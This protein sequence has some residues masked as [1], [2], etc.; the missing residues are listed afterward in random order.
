MLSVRDAQAMVRACNQAAEMQKE[1][2]VIG[3]SSSHACG[4]PEETGS[5]NKFGFYTKVALANISCLIPGSQISFKSNHERNMFR[6]MRVPKSGSKAIGMDDTPQFWC[7]EMHHTPLVPFQDEKDGREF[8]KAMKDVQEP[9]IY[10]MPRESASDTHKKCYHVFSKNNDYCVVIYGS[11]FSY[12]QNIIP[13]L[14]LKETEG[15]NTFRKSKD[16]ISEYEKVYYHYCAL[17][18]NENYDPNDKRT[19]GLKEATWKAM[20]TKD[21][22]DAAKDSSCGSYVKRALSVAKTDT[23]KKAMINKWG[24]TFFISKLMGDKVEKILKCLESL[25]VA[26]VMMDNSPVES[27]TPKD[28]KNYNLP[29]LDHDQVVRSVT[30][31][32]TERVIQVLRNNGATVT[33]PYNERSDLMKV[34]KKTWNDL[35]G[36]KKVQ[37]HVKGILEKATDKKTAA[38]I[39]LI[40]KAQNG[41]TIS[42]Y[43]KTLLFSGPPGTGKTLSALIMADQA[44][45]PMV[46]IT[47]SNLINKYVGESERKVKDIFSLMRRLGEVRGR[48]HTGP[49]AILFMDEV[50]SLVSSKQ[51]SSHTS[52]VLTTFLEEIEGFGGGS[53]FMF[54]CCTNNK[55]ALDPAF[56][57]RM[58]QVVPFNAFNSKEIQNIFQKHA[59][60]LSEEELYR[61]AHHED[62]AGLT[63]R[64]IVSISDMAV[65]ERL[66][67]IRKEAPNVPVSKLSTMFK[68]KLAPNVDTYL[69]CLRKRV[70]ANYEDHEGGTR[71]MSYAQNKNHKGPW[72]RPQLKK[73]KKPK[74]PIIVNDDEEETL[75]EISK[76]DLDEEISKNG[77]NGEESDHDNPVND[78]NRLK[79]EV[80]DDE[81]SE[82]SGE[83]SEESGDTPELA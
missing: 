54:V 33:L 82:E 62:A 57:N 74:A 3:L 78:G 24:P 70:S 79:V 39:D 34:E 67:E 32:S 65:H 26:K 81:D 52:G 7:A 4:S 49:A 63:G 16:E 55:P 40:A 41:K 60:H 69:T 21:I 51:R 48:D 28:K 66:S 30:K 37:E 2:Q 9:N 31:K 46:N 59:P 47:I 64:D 83:D 77:T 8:Q 45:I 76:K 72:A 14:S 56:V 1:N 58:A 61:I 19:H 27:E 50:D 20:E 53:E 11:L 22:I 43:P 36:S 15:G 5:A 29:E 44:G 75:E 17:Y 12:E 18:K 73:A 13:E 71:A 42:R 6:P 38:M 23:E 35:R 25:S 68:G 80:S 10:F